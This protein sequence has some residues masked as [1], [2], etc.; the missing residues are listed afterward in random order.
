MAPGAFQHAPVRV[1]RGRATRPL[2]TNLHYGFVGAVFIVIRVSRRFTLARLTNDALP[3][4]L[5][6]RLRANND[7]GRPSH[8]SIVRPTLLRR[9]RGNNEGTKKNGREKREPDRTSSLIDSR[10]TLERRNQAV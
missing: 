2:E 7:D 8:I 6:D 5:G 3:P 10:P 1:I 9:R 4:T